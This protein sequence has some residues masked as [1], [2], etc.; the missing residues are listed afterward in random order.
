MTIHPP[1]HYRDIIIR[2]CE[3]DDD[4]QD[5]SR[6]ARNKKMADSQRLRRPVLDM[7]HAAVSHISAD[8][9]N[10]IWFKPDGYPHE[11]PVDLRSAEIEG[12]GGYPDYPDAYIAS[13]E[14]ADGTK[15]SWDELDDFDEQ[16]RGL[17]SEIKF[18]QG[19][20]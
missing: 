4:E 10:M 6:M 5:L 20:W 13:I 14:Y 15:L 18:N 11:L 7:V 19:G 8:D 9:K 12:S 17:A 16:N 2:I 1:S 3:E